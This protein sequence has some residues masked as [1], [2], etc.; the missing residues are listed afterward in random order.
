MEIGLLLGLLLLLA[1]LGWSAALLMNW[2]AV[3]FGA[4][5]PTETMRQAI[6]AATLMILGVQGAC[7]AMFA[8]A[9]HSCWRS[10]TRTLT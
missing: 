9:L 4:L 6:P 3:G 1:G 10:P 7:A 5:N 2:G 8:S